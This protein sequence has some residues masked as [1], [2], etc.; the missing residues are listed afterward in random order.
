[1]IEQVVK[2][3][4]GGREWEITRARLGGFI[5]LQQ[6][7]ESLLDGVKS[8]DNRKIVAG[9]YAF[10]RVLLTDLT[11]DEFY[12]SPWTDIARAFLTIE[13]INILPHANEFSILRF[14]VAKKKP[15]GWDNPLR[16]AL[17]W[18]HILAKSY[19]WNIEEIENL[20]PEQ[21]IALIQEILADDHMDREFLHALSE[22]AYEY[23]KRTKKSHYRPLPKPIWMQFG[24]RSQEVPKVKIRKDLL[25]VGNVVFPEGADEEIVH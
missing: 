6:A 19:G 22:V 24:G 13:A 7:R 17:I 2:I 1:M 9:L 12:Q 23:N 5:R 8:D 20:W 18:V 3:A 16:S 14:A 15:V 4:L 10:L 25:P 11:E 21:A